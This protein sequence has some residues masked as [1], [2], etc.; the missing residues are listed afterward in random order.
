MDQLVD[1]HLVFKGQFAGL[2]QGL[3]ADRE[4]V[5]HLFFGLGRHVLGFLRSASKVRCSA[6]LKQVIREFPKRSTFYSPKNSP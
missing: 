5:V 3:P 2:Q 4:R 1:G 6:T